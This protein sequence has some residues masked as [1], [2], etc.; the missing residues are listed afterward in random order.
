MKNRRLKNVLISAVVAVFTGVLLLGVNA[1]IGADPDYDPPGTGVSPTFTGLTVTGDISNSSNTDSLDMEGAVVF[2]DDVGIGNRL[3]VA[4][5]T[6]LRGDIFVAP[7]TTTTFESDVVMSG[8]FETNGGNF[9]GV[10]GNEDGDF[11]VDDNMT[12]DGALNVTGEIKNTANANNGRVYVNDSLFVN[13]ATV[14]DGGL[15]AKLTTKL[16]E[17]L[18]DK[19]LYINGDVFGGTKKSAGPVNIATWLTL[20]GVLF[21]PGENPLKILDDLEV[22]GALQLNDLVATGE[23]A[24]GGALNTFDSLQIRGGDSGSI[25]SIYTLSDHLMIAPASDKLLYLGASIN[26]PEPSLNGPPLSAGHQAIL[27]RIKAYVYGSIR[28]RGSV[29]VDQ[30]VNVNGAIRNGLTTLKLNDDIQ[31][32]GPA[33]FDGNVTVGTENVPKDLTVTG[34]LIWDGLANLGG[35]R[36][37]FKD[38]LDSETQDPLN[39]REIYRV[40]DKSEVIMNCRF[41]SFPPGKVEYNSTMIQC[42]FTPDQSYW[43]VLSDIYN[44]LNNSG[45]GVKDHKVEIGFTCWDP[46]G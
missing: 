18:V 3:G 12:V 39:P 15:T 30:D 36:G 37:T 10:V 1:A 43:N 21:T 26:V 29:H 40:C 2:D 19:D 46:N 14:L 11:Y 13:G 24:I 34:E 7:D 35:G 9:R 33:Q 44:R 45:F 23:A 6:W 5:E 42:I 31:V 32:T 41:N 4:G 17:L 22:T 25:A 8:E 28:T 38:N 27:D 16:D 20:K